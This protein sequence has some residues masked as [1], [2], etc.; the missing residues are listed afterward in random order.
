M[1]ALFMTTDTPDDMD[2]IALQEELVE[3]TQNG[4]SPDAALW[5]AVL[6]ARYAKDQHAEHLAF[7]ALCEFN[8]DYARARD[9]RRMAYQMECRASG[10]RPPR[11][12][13][14]D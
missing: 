12:D 1:N 4:T 13:N 14:D 2:E 5:Q 9:H 3:L 11:L 10:L 6:E 7:A 8:G